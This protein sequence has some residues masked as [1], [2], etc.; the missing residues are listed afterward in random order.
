MFL[1]DKRTLRRV[2][3]PQGAD[4]SGPRGIDATSGLVCN[5]PVHSAG[6]IGGLVSQS[7]SCK[8]LITLLRGIGGTVFRS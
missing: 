7:A 2:V 6:Q 5:V 8:R 1:A 3:L 4:V